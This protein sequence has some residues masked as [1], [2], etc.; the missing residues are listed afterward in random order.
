PDWW[1]EPPA[2][3]NIALEP[4]YETNADGTVIRGLDATW[5]L[6]EGAG[7]IVAVE[8]EWKK[9]S[10]ANYTSSMTL[11]GDSESAKISG[12]VNYAITFDV[13]VTYETQRGNTSASAVEQVTLTVVQ[14]VL[15]VLADGQ[16]VFADFWDFGTSL[17]GWTAE[18]ATIETPSA[19]A[20]NA[21]GFHTSS[22][23]ANLV[24][25]VGLLIDGSVWDKV[26]IRM[27]R[28]TASADNVDWEKAYLYYN[29]TIRGGFEPDY[30]E[31]S[32][33]RYVVG[34]Y[35][36][37]VFDMTELSS[38][39]LTATQKKDWIESTIT[40][41]RFDPSITAGDDLANDWIG[42]GRVAPA[43]SSAHSAN[44]VSDLGFTNIATEDSANESNFKG[45]T[46]DAMNV[47]VGQMISASIDVLAEGTRR[48]RLKL[49]FLGAGD[50]VI[51]APT[52]PW[53]TVVGDYAPVKLEGLTIPTGTER[54]RG[55]LER[56]NAGSGG[57]GARYF[58][59][60]A[61]GHVVQYAPVG[62]ATSGS[63][64]Y[65]A[66]GLLLEDSDIITSNGQLVFDTMWD[67]GP[68][69]KGWTGD[70]V[71]LTTSS[72]GLVID[73][74]TT[75]SKLYS[76]DNLTIDGSRFDKVMVRLKR[77]SSG[78]G[79]EWEGPQLF[80]A[81]TD[82]I[83][84]TSYRDYANAKLVK[85][86]YSTFV[87][88]MANQSAGG[89]DW[90]NSII[91]QL[92]FDPTITSG[93]D[94]EIDWIGVGRVSPSMAV[95][96]AV[97]LIDDIGFKSFDPVDND[98]D[99]VFA[100][101]TLDYM[102]LAVGEQISASVQIF[103]NGARRGRLR[104]EFEG[105]DQYLDSPW[106]YIVDAYY[107]IEIEGETIPPGTTK[108]RGVL[109][110]ETGPSGAVGARNFTLNR[111]SVAVPY[112]PVRGDVEEGA[113]NTTD[114]TQLS[115]GAGLGNTALWG[116][117]SGGDKPDNNATRNTGALADKNS[118][119]TNDVDDE[120]ITDFGT[121][122]DSSSSAVLNANTQEKVISNV[123][124]VTGYPDGVKLFAAVKLINNL[125]TRDISVQIRQSGAG[126]ST[127]EKITPVSSNGRTF[128]VTARAK[129]F[130]G[131]R[132]YELV[133]RWYGASQD[134]NY[135]SPIIEW[136]T[137]KK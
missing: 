11:S 49:E 53:S 38:N 10:D 105:S 25:P 55:K 62:G 116:S 70:Q 114:T 42:I 12:L 121:D 85:G 74:L 6:P 133:L 46:I 94:F 106:S 107:T 93:D 99:E 50:V 30:R 95:P 65:D 54:I 135:T 34:K 61:G 68:T 111:G 83:I 14:S 124:G 101:K 73:T 22:S 102:N 120:A 24:S 15:D 57:V 64:L 136:E 2:V 69:E 117:V 134:V 77:I 130:S 113:T 78:D 72:T 115:D 3:T 82:H 96:H 41:I 97:N 89:N 27:K 47:K 110:K 58:T 100:A 127:A 23:D 40:Q 52:S 4:F 35:V 81:T 109:V 91:T 71:N 128:T 31:F 126:T 8:V 84:S 129:S 16:L 33:A 36:T 21:M 43:V 87:F 92:R 28:L 103:A 44:L 79:E 13:R 5:D 1:L 37:F 123:S 132:T 76:P 48:G 125:S 9:A 45:K 51:S 17:M 67:F 98:T 118:V 80:Y 86:T 26:I 7:S 88:D 63:N 122:T 59:L 20:S 119:D 104:L 90:T 112:S 75:D 39:S 18:N 60:N 131:T 108:I 137:A 19:S 66:D 56:E 29:T 32:N